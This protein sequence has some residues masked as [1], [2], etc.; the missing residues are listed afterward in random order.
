MMV[1]TKKC[2]RAVHRIILNGR[3]HDAM[4][5]GEIP[6]EHGVLLTDGFILLHSPESFGGGCCKSV[7]VA[8]VAN[9]LWQKLITAC[10]ADKTLVSHPFV[11]DNV[12][13]KLSGLCKEYAVTN[14]YNRDLI[15]I[16]GAIFDSVRVRTLFDIVGGGCCG[17]IASNSELFGGYP[18]LIAQKKECNYYNDVYGILL[19]HRK[20]GD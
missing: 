20:A 19:Q 2:L 14:G 10:S 18:Y 1:F 7:D 12:I 4:L 8:N 9:D 11:M 16:E 17:Y 5:S 6:C 15:T 3:S 13:T